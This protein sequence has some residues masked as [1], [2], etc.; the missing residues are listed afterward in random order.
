MSAPPD[1]TID[2]VEGLGLV[3]Q[4][5]GRYVVLIAGL[6]DRWYDDRD[7]AMFAWRCAE[8]GFKLGRA[9]A[10]SELRRLIGAK[11]DGLPR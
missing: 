6:P 8:Q 1:Y 11:H 2:Q 5:S 9:S 4:V 3:N 7:V 10:S